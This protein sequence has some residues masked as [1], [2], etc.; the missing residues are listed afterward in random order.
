M[1]RST[2]PVARGLA[3]VPRPLERRGLLRREWPARSAPPARPAA[4]ARRGHV[5]PSSALLGMA[6]C[7]C[8]LVCGLIGAVTVSPLLGMSALT[9]LSGSME[10][11]LSASDVVVVRSLAPDRIV[12]GD[13]VTFAM[14]DGSGRLM[15]HRVREVA[16]H[17]DRVDVLTRGDANSHGE[18]WSVAADG[19]VG[20]VVYRVP[21]AGALLA[22]S[23]TPIGRLLVVVLPLA[24]ITGLALRR[25]WRRPVAGVH[26]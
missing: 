21:R 13:V 9:V 26:G 11:T 22:W 14:P 19:E 3:P 2:P 4:G 24:L 12:V 20:R 10:P 6:W 7:L 5:S 15:T 23:R 25:I 8:G 1:T 17:G 18:R 16:V